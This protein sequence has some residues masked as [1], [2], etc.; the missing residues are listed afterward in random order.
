LYITTKLFLEKLNITS[1]K[2]LPI[3]GD[4]F[5]SPNEEE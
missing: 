3:L 2:E 5:Q 4:Y 1:I